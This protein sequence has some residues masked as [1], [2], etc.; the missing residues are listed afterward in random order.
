MK[1]WL[2][3]QHCYNNVAVLVGGKQHCYN[4]VAFLV[5]KQHCYNN[6]ASTNQNSNIVITMLLPSTKKA[7]L[8]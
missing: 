2:Q 5:G 8:L 1:Q 6:V 7:T 4:Y 3:K